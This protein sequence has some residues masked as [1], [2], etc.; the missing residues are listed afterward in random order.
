MRAEDDI[1]HEGSMW[2][3]NAP[4]EPVVVAIE[5]M[6]IAAAVDDEFIE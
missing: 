2:L 6:P 3:T 4:S 1:D 5:A